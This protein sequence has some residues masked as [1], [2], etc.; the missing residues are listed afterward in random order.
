MQAK[1]ELLKRITSNP[2]IFSGK[3][4]IRGMRFPVSDILG[5]MAAGM[6]PDQIIEEFPFLEQEDFSAALLYAS[7][8]LSNTRIVYAA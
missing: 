2:D 1:E 8:S 6:S 5:L 4:I 7:L 3:P